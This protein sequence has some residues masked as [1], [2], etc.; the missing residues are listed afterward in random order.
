MVLQEIEDMMM[1]NNMTTIYIVRHGE[2][3]YNALPKKDNYISGQYG[4]EGAP[5]TKKGKEQA[6]KRAEHLKQIPFDA[7][8]SSDLARAK[9]TAKIMKLEREIAIQTTKILRERLTYIIPGKTFE[10]TKEIIKYALKDLDE[11]AK[12]AHKPHHTLENANETAARIITFLREVAVAYKNGTV[13]IINHGNNM[14]A[15]LQHLGYV[16]YDELL[17]EGSIENTAYIVLESDGV[18]FFIKETKGIHINNA[19]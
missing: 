4:I 11:K 6:H 2:S 16:T 12:M 10:E 3:E 18:D 9:Q 17:F 15:L 1:K 13:L 5:L 7:I 19:K 14:I 8:F